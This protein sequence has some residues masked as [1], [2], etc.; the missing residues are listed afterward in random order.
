MT[1]GLTGVWLFASDLR[2]GFQRPT[3]H[4]QV[5]QAGGGEVPDVAL[6]HADIGEI[7]AVC[8]AFHLVEVVGEGAVQPTG[9]ADMGHAAA[10]EEFEEGGASGRH[11]MNVP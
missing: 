2:L 11:G 4:D 9:Q 10:G 7:G 6:F 5:G 8:G 3:A 1:G